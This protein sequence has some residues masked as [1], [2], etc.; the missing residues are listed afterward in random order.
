MTDNYSM[1]AIR[2]IR[3]YAHTNNVAIQSADSPY[4]EATVAGMKCDGL[5]EQNKVVIQ[6]HGKLECYF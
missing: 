5:D 4:G 6:Y 2:F 1:E 3:W